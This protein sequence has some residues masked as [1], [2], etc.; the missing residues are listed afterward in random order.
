MQAYDPRAWYWKVGGDA[1]QVYSSAIGD[2]VPIA[3]P[4]YE[5][6][7]AGG[8]APTNIANADELAEV[9]ATASVRPAHT[10]LLDRYKDS[11]AGRLTMELV[12][13]VLFNHENRVRVLEG[14]QPITAN[15][16]RAALKA[17]L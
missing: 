14:K 9:L 11:Q 8:N 17:M 15:Q 12:A 10:D 1:T 6:W 13:K 4:G 7:L 16:F 3:N 2:Y 5:A